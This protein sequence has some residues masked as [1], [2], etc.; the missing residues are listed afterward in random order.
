MGQEGSSSCLSVRLFCNPLVRMNRNETLYFNLIYPDTLFYVIK[1]FSKT[2]SR[3]EILVFFWPG[4]RPPR[5][6]SRL[7]VHKGVPGASGASKLHF[8]KNFTKQK[9]Q[10]AP[11]LVGAGHLLGTQIRIWKDLG[12]MSFWRHVHSLWR[13]WGCGD[14]GVHFGGNVIKQKLPGTPNL[15]GVRFVSLKRYIIKVRFVGLKMCKIKVC[16]VCINMYKNSEN[17]NCNY[18][19]YVL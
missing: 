4:T 5:P 17:T 15:V 12:P 18:L 14:S 3:G 13:G 1:L 6:P 2:Y 7:R 16:F 10:G 19:L 11:D 9:L 8:D